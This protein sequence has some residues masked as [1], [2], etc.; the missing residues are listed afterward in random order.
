MSETLRD[1]FKEKKAVYCVDSAL[2]HMRLSVCKVMH[3]LGQPRS[4]PQK[5]SMS[6]SSR[7]QGWQGILFGACHSMLATE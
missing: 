6:S 4:Q 2:A 1:L 5:A 3:K 7:A